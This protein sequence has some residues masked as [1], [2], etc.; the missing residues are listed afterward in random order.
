MVLFF[1]EIRILF[2]TFSE[3]EFSYTN[4]V[5]FSLWLVQTL[6]H[7]YNSVT[8]LQHYISET[9]DYKFYPENNFQKLRK[10]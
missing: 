4:F 9:D 5:I 8:T 3:Q 2:V 7:K 10:I 6:A 1:L